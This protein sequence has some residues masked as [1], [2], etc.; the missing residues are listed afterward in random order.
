MKVRYTTTVAGP[1]T[2][3]NGNAGDVREIDA[4]AAKELIGT[5]AVVPV[6]PTE[7]ASKR[8]A[9]APEAKVEKRG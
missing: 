7:Q 4:S 2:A 5:K 6:G 1:N 9:K 3:L 8:T